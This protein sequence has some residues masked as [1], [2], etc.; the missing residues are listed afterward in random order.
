MNNGVYNRSLFRKK[1][2]EARDQLRRM[3]GIMA[4]SPELMQAGMMDQAPMAPQ[5][6][7]GE[8]RFMAPNLLQPTTPQQP[9][10]PQQGM[11]QRPMPQQSPLPN[12]TMIPQPAS[13]LSAAGMVQPQ[14]AYR[15]GGDVSVGS[16]ARMESRSFDTPTVTAG[17][18]QPTLPAASFDQAVQVG[19]NTAAAAAESGLPAD[20]Q[21]K[22]AQ[23]DQMMN[24]PNISDTQ[25]SKAIADAFGLEEAETP[26]ATV[27]NAATKLGLDPAREARIDSLNKAMLGFAIAAGTSPRASEN[28]ANGMLA[29]LKQMRDTEVRK[30]E[31]EL[32]A[33]TGALEDEATSWFDTPRGK[34]AVE[35]IT[36]GVGAN[37]SVS[38]I[39][40]ELNEASTSNG[41]PG[42]LGDELRQALNA[43]DVP[44]PSVQPM[45]AP[46]A[47][48]PAAAPAAQPETT[49]TT[50]P[51]NQTESVRNAQTAVDRIKTSPSLSPEE[52]QQRLAAVR[53]RLIESGINPDLVKY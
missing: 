50:E 28:I 32:A 37:K 53:Q 31:V 48:A 8:V 36:K 40:D 49:Q 12:Q 26:E 52:K 5:T 29:G 38:D 23:I 3:G 9:M 42:T 43:G 25:K 21:E 24:D 47:P 2:T 14:M 46:T 18:T 27:Q 10:L 22:Y 4:S 19:S 33:R 51:P 15:D 39:V 45:I 34:L 44:P 13:T 17:R 41:V 6:G 20:L 35:F 16:R 1:G 30:A 11:P 7:Q